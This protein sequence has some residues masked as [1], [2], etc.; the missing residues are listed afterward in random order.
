M[1]VYCNSHSISI[2]IY[3]IYIITPC[4]KKFDDGC[5]HDQLELAVK[6]DLKWRFSAS[7]LFP[8]LVKKKFHPV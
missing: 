5:T 2:S 7:L 6:L 1:Y 8:Y 4:E 3:R